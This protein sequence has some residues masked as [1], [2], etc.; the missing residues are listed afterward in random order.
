[1]SK[2]DLVSRT[3]NG[4]KQMAKSVYILSCCK[5]GVRYASVSSA[6][7]NISNEP[8]SL[9]ISMEKSASFSDLLTPDTPFAVNILGAGQQDIVEHCMSAKGEARFEA[10]DWTAIDE[11]PV[12]SGAQASFIC[13]V[14]EIIILET[15]NIVFAGIEESICNDKS[16]ALVYVAGKFVPL[17]SL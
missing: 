12:L 16:S 5:Q 3:G 1:M 14:S 10:G 15:H 6:V 9:L 13:R 7:C 11:Q 8:P 4:F 17:H 2:A